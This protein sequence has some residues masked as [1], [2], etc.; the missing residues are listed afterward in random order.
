[1][2]TIAALILGRFLSKG[3]GFLLFTGILALFSSCGL[4]ED[5]PQKIAKTPDEQPVMWKVRKNMF[6][7]PLYIM[8]NAYPNS[9]SYLTHG[10]IFNNVISKIDSCLIPFDKP[11]PQLYQE[12]VRSTKMENGMTLD[13]LLSQEGVEKLKNTLN[14]VRGI[15]YQSLKAAPPL[16]VAEVVIPALN[17]ARNNPTYARKAWELREKT[18]R[19]AVGV[20]SPGI[21]SNLYQA[22]PVKAQAGVL[23]QVF[24]NTQK[25]KDALYEMA[26]FYAIPN[27]SKWL[28][29]RKKAYPFPDRYDSTATAHITAEWLAAI[30]KFQGSNPLL[31]LVGIPY[32]KG[33]D[34]LLMRL[35]QA[36]YEVKPYEPK[37]FPNTQKQ[38]KAD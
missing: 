27:H 29:A 9:T 6:K 25:T 20:L 18:Y 4:F 12:L 33:E 1:M 22:V 36:G 2:K 14:D 8:A 24:N 16:A 31:A 38:Q 7:E 21:F 26:R 17:N 28:K 30:E 15:N 5:Q 37:R 13:S 11:R 35:K 32:L 10:R 23:E 34:G 19:P 3:S